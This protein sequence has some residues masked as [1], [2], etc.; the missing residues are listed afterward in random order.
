MR[1]LIGTDDG[2]HAARWIPGERSARV[3]GSDLEG[4]AV[5]TVIRAGDLAYCSGRTKG[6]YR[7]E[8]RGDR[9]IRAST[10]PAGRAL[11]SLAAAPGQ[12]HV[13][14]TGTEPAAI[15][16]SHDAGRSWTELGSFSDLGRSVEWRGYGSRDPH[17]QHLMLDPTEDWRI[18]AA[19]EIGGAYRSDDSG[20]TWR[21]INDGLYDDL[22]ALAVDPH[23]T[24]R[25]LAATGGGLYRS[26]DRGSTWAAD[27]GTLGEA[28]CTA[29]QVRR[30]PDGDAAW[31]L[32]AT[33]AGPPGSWGQTEG[34]ADARLHLSRDSGD[35]WETLAV[36]PSYSSRAGLSALA[37]DEGRSE[38]VFVGTTDGEV[39]YGGPELKGWSRVLHGLAAVRSLAVI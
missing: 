13:L 10:P 23:D 3:E 27:P 15:Y 1:L 35:G 12:P 32:V 39:Y 25:I 29:L 36:K 2:V 30:A 4:D 19:V 14:Y 22:H 6:I 7:T 8:D 37:L 5:P 11:T 9:W 31:V 17:V 16:A 34:G 21:P 33:A 26:T 20:R 28:Y 38:G 24:S 18:Y